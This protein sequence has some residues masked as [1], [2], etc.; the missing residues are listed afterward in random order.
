MFTRD[1]AT[2]QSWEYRPSVGVERTHPCSPLC[3]W[4]VV[5]VMPT[6]GPAHGVPPSARGGLS[7]GLVGEPGS[8]GSELC[9]SAERGLGAVRDGVPGGAG[10]P[11][12]EPGEAEP[13]EETLPSFCSKKSPN[14][15]PPF[16]PN[17]VRGKLGPGRE[18][19]PSPR[20]PD[21]TISSV[22][23]PVP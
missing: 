8:Q 23:T 9:V 4:D 7:A 13:G 15:L 12:C 10:E 16:G 1:R 22:L 2:G 19:P 18:L 20:V 3:C 14:F 5:V 6:W 17:Q 21:I 11:L